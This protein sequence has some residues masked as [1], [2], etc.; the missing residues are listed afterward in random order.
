VCVC[1]RVCACAVRRYDQTELGVKGDS[2]GGEHSK[3][4]QTKRP[5][6][7]EALP[8]FISRLQK[9]GLLCGGGEEGMTTR[10][11]DLYLMAR[12]RDGVRKRDRRTRYLGQFSTSCDTS[13]LGHWGSGP[14]P[15]PSGLN[16]L[17]SLVNI[18]I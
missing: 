3:H 14:L 7:H 16:F 4:T 17:H 11:C 13:S 5:T 9:K 18:T 2:S 10:S 1:V 12:F 15:I 6:R 8:D